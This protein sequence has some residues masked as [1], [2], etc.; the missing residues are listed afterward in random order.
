[1]RIV[2]ISTAHD[3][4]VAV[5]CDGQ[6]EFFLKEERVTRKKHDFAPYSAMSEAANFLAGK[7]V[8][9]LAISTVG[10]I[11][12]NPN[13]KPLVDC[14][15]K[16]FKTNNVFDFYSDH[17]LCH[18]SL[19]FYNSGFDKAICVIVDRNGS[20]HPRSNKTL[21]ESESVFLAEYPYSFEEIQKN[22]WVVTAGI[23]TDAIINQVI[24]NDKARFPNREIKASSCYGIT[25]VYE[26]A[27]TFI[28]QA[29]LENGKTMG[30]A[31]YGQENDQFPKLFLDDGTPMDPL[32]THIQ[33]RDGDSP[34]VINRDFIAK[35]TKTVTP[36]KHKLYADYAYQVQKQT[37]E[38]V[39]K[40]I[41]S[42][43]DKTEIKNVCISGGYGL[44][45]VAN[46]YY[47]SKFPDVNFFFEPIADD[48]G[49]SL[50]AA[51]LVYRQLTE[52]TRVL[53]IK[54]TFFNGKE[55]SLDLNNV[56][57]DIAKNVKS[58]KVK[59]NQLADLLASNKSVALFSG[60]AEAGP[61]SLG[62]R[63]IL[64]YP[65]LLNT[66]DIINKIKK[67]EWYRPFAA[68]VLEEDADKYF[69][70]MGIKNSPYMTISFEAKQQ[71]KEMFPG[72]VHV[73]GSCRIQTVD[74]EN[75]NLYNILKEIKK[76]TG[77]GILLNTSFNLAGEPLVD[78]LE[79]SLEVLLNSDLDFLWLPDEK[80]I[81]EKRYN[82]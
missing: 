67:R 79:Q 30:L 17:H 40:I 62:N 14:A 29:I 20:S 27:T 18:A 63:S 23:E 53:P 45:V 33:A 75:S 21:V 1:L 34:A 9:A 49:N 44:N 24:F 80:L 2:G 32:F 11:E 15:I 4:S 65:N 76:K 3:S 37:Q 19:A 55:P 13:I 51:M 10:I 81:Y 73:D 5:Y 71:T 59:I 78:N 43:V 7:K 72:I 69:E 12:N 52:D 47:I 25:K 50:G 64:F 54:T 38:E 39:A 22:Y 82:Q 56:S 66:K 42:A 57:K 58:K 61:R 8:D 74:K 70:M 41:K 6:I 48:T 28:G 26:S 60:K 77:H 31:A 16:L 36:E 68:C 35:M 46:G